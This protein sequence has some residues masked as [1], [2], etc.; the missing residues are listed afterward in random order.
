MVWSGSH[1]AALSSNSLIFEPLMWFY[2]DLPV[3]SDFHLDQDVISLGPLKIGR[4]SLQ[5]PD[6][7]A[8]HLRL[9]RWHPHSS[10]V[11]PTEGSK[12]ARLRFVEH[13]GF[14]PENVMVLATD[15]MIWNCLTTRELALP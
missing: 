4:N 12:A 3:D 10:D 2:P 9:V 5:L 11:V 13:L 15:S 1:E 6:T 7:L 14:K 8:E